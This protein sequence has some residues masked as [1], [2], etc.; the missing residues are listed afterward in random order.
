MRILEFFEFITADDDLDSPGW[1]ARAYNQGPRPS[2]RGASRGLEE[3]D[4]PRRTRT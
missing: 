3:G 1:T 2:E 4:D